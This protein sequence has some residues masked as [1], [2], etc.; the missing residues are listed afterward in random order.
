MIAHVTPYR[1]RG[2]CWDLFYKYDLSQYDE[3]LFEG[4][5]GGGKTLAYSWF[6]HNACMQ[7]PGCNVLM[8]RKTRD[9]MSN[10][11]M[12]T[13][14]DQVLKAHPGMEPVYLGRDRTQREHW[15]YE[16]T[17]RVVVCG[18]NDEQRILS[19]EWDIIW[20]NEATQLTVADVE[21]LTTR[22]RPSGE[23]VSPY[24]LLLLDCNPSYYAHHLNHRFM[25]VNQ[26]QIRRLRLKSRHT[27]NP[28]YFNDD[29]TKT[30]DG[31]K[32]MAK[33]DA[34]TGSRRKRYYLGEW[35]DEEG[36]VYDE[37]E[38]DYHIIKRSDVPPIDYYFGS[39][40]WGYRNAGV[41]QV[42]GVDKEERMYLV[43]ETYQSQRNPDWWCEQAVKLYQEFKLVAIV[44]DPAEPG[45]RKQF[46]DRL[47]RFKSGPN[48]RIAIE[49]DNDRESG[50]YEVKSA[51][52]REDHLSTCPRDCQE[53]GKHG[54]ARMYFVEDALRWGRDPALAEQ[55]G[56]SVCT[57]DEIQT[58][59][60]LQTKDGRPIKEMWDDSIPHDGLDATRY[61][62]KFNFARHSKR[63][64]TRNPYPRGS[65]GHR[66]WES[67]LKI[68]RN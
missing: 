22:L 3:V 57:T 38:A 11:C 59:P 49:A 68:N 45:L 23:R 67:G 53:S 62:A 37:F 55:A 64:K 2:A 27:D 18:M 24:S 65:V 46:N 35:A 66:M 30:K 6:I 20:G 29:G 34:L 21:M 40:D 56:R 5:A 31:A 4:V 42:W 51:L 1:P 32:Y 54:K 26:G 60:W 47:S 28:R 41:L 8:V 7:Y 33:L 13:Y 39:C 48:P 52:L 16:N 12:R 50:M 10:S 61:A 44:C 43:H 14:E 63:R 58:L 9:S 19:T 17:S 15:L 25:P 36:R